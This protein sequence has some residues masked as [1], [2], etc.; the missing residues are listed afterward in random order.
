MIL[1]PIRCDFKQTPI[2][3][4]GKPLLTRAEQSDY[5]YCIYLTNRHKHQ[6][7]IYIRPTYYFKPYK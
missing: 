5:K 1:Q 6:T 7:R 2:M 4:K 3:K